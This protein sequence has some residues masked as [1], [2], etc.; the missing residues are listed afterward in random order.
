MWA[1]FWEWLKSAFVVGEHTCDDPD[2]DCEECYWS[3][4]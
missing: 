1:K 2:S 3:A 4:W